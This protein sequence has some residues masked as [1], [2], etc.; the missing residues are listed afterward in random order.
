M[1]NLNLI[2]RLWTD[3]HE[4]QSP[5][6]F[7][8]Y[9]AMLIMLLTLGVGQ[10]WATD[11]LY[12]GYIKASFNGNNCW[13]GNYYEMYSGGPN[14]S[15]SSAADMGTLASTFKITS[16][17]WKLNSDYKVDHTWSHMWWNI[18]N[19]SST[20]KDQHWGSYNNTDC[21]PESSVDYTV[22]RYT[23]ASGIHYLNVGFYSEFWW[24]S[25]DGD[26]SGTQELK[27]YYFKYKILPPSVEEGN[28]FT[29]EPSN[30]VSG[31]GTSSDP[32]IISYGNTTAF[33]VTANK[34][35]SDANSKLK[36][37]FDNGSSWST[38]ASATTTSL[39]SGSY[40][41]DGTK[42]NITIK[43]KFNNSTASLDGAVAE[44]TIYYI[45]QTPG[46]TVVAGDHGKVK[47][48][49]G[50][51]WASSATISPVAASTAYN[52]YANPDSYYDFDEW[53]TDDGTHSSFADAESASTTVT[54]SAGY[55]A[56]TTVTA[57]F[58]EHPYTITIVGGTASSTT[59]GISTTK[60]TAT[61]SV[62]FGKRFTGWT[63][64]GSNFALTDGTTTSSTTI[65]FNATA[66][67]TVT[68]NF[69]QNYAFI[70]GRFHVTNLERTGSWTNTFS[71]GDWDAN[72]TAIRF[73]YD[74]VNHRFYRRTYA[75]PKELTSKISNYDPIFFI[76]T[77]TSSSSLSGLGTYMSTTAQELSAAGTANKRA[78]SSSSG[79]NNNLKFNSTD[80]T[81]YAVIYFDGSYIWYEL[82]QRL[83][84][85]GN[86]S[87][88]GSVASTYHARSTNATAAANGFS[89]TGHDFT[90]W[91][92]GPSSGTSYAAGAT[93][94]ISSS[95]VTL[96]AQWTP[97]SYDIT[98][99]PASPTN[100]AYTVKPSTGTYNTS[101][102]ITVT[103]NQNYKITS[104][105]ANRTGSA[106]TSVSVSHTAA[107]KVYTFTQPAY[108]VT[109]NVT[110]ASYGL[111]A[112]ISS[113]SYESRTFTLSKSSTYN[114][115][116]TL[117][118]NWFVYYVCTSKPDCATCTIDQSTG[119]ATVDK[120]G[121]YTFKVQYRTASGGSG[122]LLAESSGV[123]GT[124]RTIPN[125][126]TLTINH[127]KYSDTYMSGNGASA[128]PYFV[129]LSRATAYGKLN[130]TATLPAEL[131]SG[132]QLW[133][134]VDGTEKG[135]VTVDGT[136]A[137]V[138]MDLPTKTVG[139]DRTAAIKFYSKLDG[140]A[141]PDAKKA[142]ATVYY[143]VSANPAVT[144]SATYND[145]PVV[146]EI[147]QNATIVVSATATNISGSPTFQYKKGSGGSY[148]STTSY[149]LEAAGT[150][151]MYAKTTALGDNW[152]GTLDVTTYA[153][154][155]VTYV[156]SKTDM[157][158]DVATTSTSRLFKSSGEEH[159]A[160]EI[161]GYTFTGWTCSNSNVQVSDDSGSSYKSSSSNATVYV[162]A[163]AAGGTLT[164]SYT[165][166][167]RI[168]FD[169]RNTGWGSVYVYLFSGSS[170]W[171][172]YTGVYV[173]GRYAEYGEM[174]RIG[175]SNIYYYEYSSATINHIAFCKNDQHGYEKFSS[176]KAAFRSD[177][178]R[179]NPVFVPNADKSASLNYGTVDYFNN[180][181]W[182]RY[183]P[184]KSGYTLHFADQE[185]PFLPEDPSVDAEN[186]KVTV[187]R[188]ASTTYPIY[189]NNS[190]RSK[191]WKNASDITKD[192]C[193]N[194]TLTQTSGTC[195]FYTTAEG[196]YVFRLSTANGQV[197]LTVEYPLSTGD[198]QVY[199]SDNTGNNNN[200]SNYIRKNSSGST[201]QDKVSFFIKKNAT[202]TFQIKRCTGF[203]G[204]TPTWENVGSATAITVDKD[205]VYNLIFQQNGDGSTISKV[206]QEY[207]SGNYYIRTDGAEGGWGNY[208]SNPDNIMKHTDKASALAAG[209]NYYYLRWIGDKD[210]NSTANVKFCI[211]T[212]Y[213]DC[214][215]QEHGNDPADGS[216]SGGQALTGKGANVRFTYHP[217]TN[218]T[219]RT[220]VGGSAHDDQYLVINGTNLKTSGDASWS[221]RTKM[222]DLN[223]WI[224]TYELKA[225][226][227]ATITLESH[228]NDK[229][230]T[231]LPTKTV[232]KVGD[233]TYYDLRIV[234]DY[235][236]N[237]VVAAY[238]PS[239]V[240][241]DLT[242]DV[243][244]M[245]IRQAKDNHESAPTTTL[246]LS[247]GAK[248]TGDPKTLYG[249]IKFEKDYVRG[250]GSYSGIA[251]SKRSTYW[252]SFPFDV[253][254]KDIFGLGD[255]TETWILQRYRGDLRASKGW[256]LD[257]PTFWE[258]IL[259]TEYVLKA[260]EG[261][262]LSLD[263][264]AIQWPNS[265]TTQYLYFPSKNKVSDITS[266]MPSASMDVP[267]L[268]C[269]I[270][271][272]ADRT[273]KDANWNVIGIPGF[274]DAWG[275]ATET[276]SVVGGDLKYFYTWDAATNTLSTTSSRKYN[277]KF[278]H[279]YM[280]QYYGNIDWSA[281]EPAA[282]P[283]RRS[284][285][286]KPKEVEFQLSLTQGEQEA[287]H[288]FITLMDKEQITSG[289]DMN[290]DLVKM[291]N[292]NKTNIYTI[293]NGD[294]QAAANCLPMTEQ[295]TV[296]PVG[297][298]I[299]K[300]G[301]YTFSI[302][303]GTNGVGV[304]LIDNETG[305]RTSLS[306]LDYT[307]N[308]SAGT[309]E[310][311]FVLE[312][313]P[314]KPV[315]TGME[316][317]NDE[318]GRNGVRKVLIDGLLYI[319]K[320]GKMFDAQGR[321]VK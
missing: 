103:P 85:D 268:E 117:N 253:R 88:S 280:V 287:D 125:R 13:S 93:V 251:R 107:T 274:A 200:Y 308:L 123:T 193:S 152:E 106:G 261:Y 112:S 75:T 293:I 262:V 38:G 310:S 63:V 292:A 150:T 267:E 275:K 319:V 166:N 273:I 291:E 184:A 259:D 57:N 23:D 234:Y 302:L 303:D 126:S 35:H 6:R 299:A 129:Y 26:K 56:V 160:A 191:T 65:K 131:A 19:G 143:T 54:L 52:I 154:N 240:S 162:K 194:L 104:V 265:Q 30:L 89:K 243:D 279:S 47:K 256:F 72:S 109:L 320:D 153:A 246:T 68:A 199:Y 185:V 99:N 130:L 186:F 102:S 183:M 223:D 148:S 307:I 235:K 41:P 317:L 212:D 236:T 15:T 127:A 218:T 96:Y 58:K 248:I 46:I 209:Y 178:S 115:E 122:T 272:P 111:T 49:S 95:D 67:G 80:Q 77:S 40:T 180:G 244:I 286:A 146:G 169:D 105:T 78:L 39:T 217:G 53:T 114:P 221:G 195:N 316:L 295:T 37:S 51:S 161:A 249:A 298:K 257:T 314:I 81:G 156:T 237:E 113:K 172:A 164:A 158:G 252:I 43:V 149:T 9:A 263:C 55:S 144:V 189:V 71:S 171:D 255:Y 121:D 139:A 128:T 62:P 135:Q 318:N 304:T 60:G 116:G 283:A 124:M 174:T 16:V 42:R 168:Y 207:Y 98:Y 70:E 29:V 289:F 258:Y 31:T 269:T 276:V 142:S 311:R 74:A 11:H 230:V 220:C 173:N 64:P 100:F 288:T 24:R 204:S 224:Y 12:N 110:A 214:V 137:S 229:Y 190:C 206:G 210:G 197:K 271:A 97:K 241:S 167:K 170:P 321:Q 20:T 175:E 73:E 94:P 247:S 27:T 5:Q 228:Y 10:M 233:A 242:I 136:A 187:L 245:F 315:A 155:A 294:V 90:G 222:N 290:S 211:A 50:D 305:I 17:K 151:T 157:Y 133:Y 177:F 213:N 22:A 140:Q 145:E 232:L 48:A 108:G 101:V 118:T 285:N 120:D 196:D 239:T 8:R 313:S 281:S 225:A 278:M 201:K 66:A 266:V 1:K 159:T 250:E 87:T 215:S 219:T 59:A 282:V 82:E 3:S 277:F 69:A 25:G 7:A 138:T 301:D 2:E 312:I 181:Y 33:T 141:A 132:E 260:G 165:E 208:L 32:F 4:K 45:E 203:S 182:R 198:Y 188:A 91:K 254:V 264:E 18:D 92:T 83:K 44:R 231:I 86:G 192:N 297:V 226:D 284:T 76:K 309:Y 61:V 238:I 14:A 216:L 306:A 296:V 36:V 79:S 21:Y 134:S 34:E 227:E 163:T 147:P 179:C 270:T 202:P 205:S 119:V 28:D 84:Y 176:T 300:T